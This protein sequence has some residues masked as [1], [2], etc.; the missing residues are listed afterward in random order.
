MPLSIGAIILPASILA[1]VLRMKGPAQK[2]V[3]AGA[4]SLETARRPLSVGIQADYMIEPL[5]RSGVLV[6]AGDGRYYADMARIRRRNRLLYGV[7]A[8]M[9]LVGLTFIVVAWMRAR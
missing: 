7:C 6:A 9:A 2:F 8:V 4:V 5:V 3:A 1:M